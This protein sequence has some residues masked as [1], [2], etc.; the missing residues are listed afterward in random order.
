MGTHGLW[1]VQLGD[2]TERVII[3]GGGIGALSTA[4]ELSNTEVQR[5][6][7]DI[8]V[9]QMGWRLGGKCATGRNPNRANRI[10]E[11]GIHGFLGS[12]FNAL[13]LMQRVY[14]EWQQPADSPLADFSSAFPTENSSFLWERDGDQLL[15]WHITRDVSHGDIGDAH[16]FGTLLSWMRALPGACLLYTSPSPRD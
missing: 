2:A 4:F 7:Y 14:D 16:K 13:T 11:H 6:R 10:E 8:T 15:R 3:V 9:Y 1:E 12:Y 5:E